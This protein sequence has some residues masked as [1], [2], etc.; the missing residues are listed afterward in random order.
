MINHQMFS[1]NLPA[2]DVK[3]QE[4]L[5]ERLICEILIGVFF[6]SIAKI[7]NPAHFSVCC[8]I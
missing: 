4:I 3:M 7:V 1:K 5:F 2:T 6:S 8:F